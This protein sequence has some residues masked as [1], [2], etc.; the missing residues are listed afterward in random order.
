MISLSVARKRSRF[1]AAAALVDVGRGAEPLQWFSVGR[2]LRNDARQ[3][4]AVQPVVTAQPVQDLDLGAGVDPFLIRALGS[5]EVVGMHDARPGRP[6]IERA[7]D[8]RRCMP[9]AD[10]SNTAPYRRRRPPRSGAATTMPA[11]E[12]SARTTSSQTQIR[13]IDIHAIE[14]RSGRRS[15]WTRRSSGAAYPLSAIPTRLRAGSVAARLQQSRRRAVDRGPPTVDEQ[16]RAGDVAG[17]VRHEEGNRG[18]DLLGPAPAAQHGVGRV[19]F[20]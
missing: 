2:T 4:P 6:A 14:Q 16:G 15:P 10:R 19:L 1:F 5:L 8:R 3:E 20:P 12:T 9:P 13:S 17:R 11:R 7:G 18:P